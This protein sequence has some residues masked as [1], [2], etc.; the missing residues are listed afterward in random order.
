MRGAAVLLV[1]MLLTGCGPAEQPLS[2]SL[3]GW[4]R[5][6]DMRNGCADRAWRF[7]RDTVVMRRN[8]VALGTFAIVRSEVAG[9]EVGLTLR[10]ADEAA[11][12][13]AVATGRGEMAETLPR[14]QLLLNLRVSQGRISPGAVLIRED[15]PKGLRA[16]SRR[17]GRLIERF[18]TME[19]CAA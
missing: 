3:A 19:R 18:F 2:P 12:L 10:V 8:G 17:E 16:A 4:W 13:A 11:I 1:V 9:A 6:L 7:D 5:P 14:T 15:G